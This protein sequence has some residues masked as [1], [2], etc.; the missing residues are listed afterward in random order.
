MAEI[1]GL[2]RQDGR[3]VNPAHAP[4]WDISEGR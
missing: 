1:A 3:V 4:V 2:K